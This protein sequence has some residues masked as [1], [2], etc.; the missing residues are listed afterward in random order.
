[1]KHSQPISLS[2]G[3]T[4]YVSFETP[5]QCPM[6]RTFIT[7]DYAGGYYEEENKFSILYFCPSCKTTFITRYS[8]FEP[9]KSL[10][11]NFVEIF[12]EEIHTISP[13]FENIYNQSLHAEDLG[14]TD[15]CGMGYRKS[16][17]FLIKDYCMFINP[18]ESET[19]KSMNL[20]QCIN[21]YL[22][23]YKPLQ[24][25]STIATWLGNDESH[26]IKKFS[27]KDIN[28]LKKY[29]IAA[30]KYIEL[31]TLQGEASKII[32]DHYNK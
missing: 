14:L 24:D 28:E 20:S 31:E 29:I 12:S 27:D 32:S 4:K 5:N 21:K 17:E 1:M 9:I 8:G 26:Y 10:P 18:N 22:V 6:C 25:V 16:L 23:A 7:P 2:S 19:I 30:T 3:G 11:T 15:I 13:N